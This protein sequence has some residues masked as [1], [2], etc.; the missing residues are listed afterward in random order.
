MRVGDVIAG[1]FVLTGRGASGGMGAVYQARDQQSGEGVA[2]KL[3]LSEDEQGVRRMLQEGAALAALSH[4][5]IVRY[6][7]HGTADNGLPYVAMEWVTGET[8]SHR[9]ARAPLSLAD[10]L[11]VVRQVAEALG[12][13]HGRGIVHRDVKPSNVMLS[14]GKTEGVKLLDFGVAR[15][16]RTASLTATHAV[17]GTPAYMAPEQARGSSELTPAADVFSLG[18]VLYRCLSGQPPFQGS[19]VIAILSKVLLEEPRDLGE[20]VPS[21]PLPVVALCRSLLSKPP[22]ERPPDG[23]AVARE[24]ERLEAAVA[25]EAA[26]ATA[27]IATLQESESGPSSRSIGHGELRLI[28]VLLASRPRSVAAD[29]D[30]VTRTVSVDLGKLTE[31]TRRHGGS[32]EQLLDGTLVISVSARGA[33]TDSAAS[34]ARLALALRSSLGGSKLVLATGRGAVRGAVPMGD[35]IDRAGAL[36]RRAGHSGIHIDAVTA[37]LL[38]ARFEVSGDDADLV[39]VRE[40]ETA[41]PA[42]TVL[43]KTTPFVG[44]ERESRLLFGLLEESAEE[45][46][47]AVALVTAPPG[48]GKS[49]LSHELIARARARDPN[50]VVLTAAADP[51]SDGAPLHVLA[52]LVRREAGL[53][54]GA[55]DAL[56]R[57]QLSARVARRVPAEDARRVAAFL[58]EV[59]RVPFP[60]A[61]DE[62]LAAA[63]RET[64]LMGDQILLAFVDFLSH[65]TRAAPVL[66]LLDDLHWADAPSVDILDAALRSLR[67]APLAI[68]GFARPEVEGR[69][70]RLFADRDLVKVPLGELAKKGAERLVRAVLGDDVDDEGVQRLVT[71]AAG[72]AFLLEELIRTRSEQRGSDVPESALAIV[73]ARLETLPEVSRRVLRA[74]SVFGNKFWSAG[75]SELLG[76]PESTQWSDST[77]DHLEHAE[78]IVRRPDSG[79][80]GH[81]EWTFRHALTRDAAYATLL[82]ADRVIGHRLAAEWLERIGVHDALMIAEHFERGGERLRAAA[83]LQR[84]A[85]QALSANDFPAV[86]ALAERALASGV[87]GATRASLQML[88]AD[89]HAWRGQNAAMAE[90]ALEARAGFVPGSSGWFRATGSAGFALGRSGELDRAE[91][92]GREALTEEPG[93]ELAEI[94]RGRALTRISLNLIL[95]HRDLAP[96]LLVAAD[97]V[98]KAHPNDGEVQARVHGAHALAASVRNDVGGYLEHTRLVLAARERF[99][100][101]RNALFQLSNLGDGLVRVGAHQ[102]A[103]ALLRRA[104]EQ[105]G[106]LGLAPNAA[107]AR[108]NLARAL[109]RQGRL[110]AALEVALEARQAFEKQGDPRLSALAN[111]GVADVCSGLGRHADALEAAERGIALAGD[112]PTAAASARAALVRALLDAQE[113]ARAD[114][115]AR[116]V[117][118]VLDELGELE[119]DDARA[120]LACAEAFRAAGALDLARG[121]LGEALRRLDTLAA[122]LTDPD[123]RERFSAMEENRRLRELE[124]ELSAAG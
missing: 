99:G 68:F 64:R 5:G 124:R 12:Y 20:L 115:Q 16:G 51:A 55:D 107:V 56:S 17:I 77:L 118:R 29:P 58:G 104:V 65:E 114:E 31:L 49:R 34:V 70:P 42:R 90:K 41:E 4:P 106:R 47:A 10:A 117:A 120:R 19:D 59:C 121:M 81:R 44:R 1:R 15:L 43:G 53:R 103:E 8:L 71:Q 108:H 26:R 85:E 84:A 13:A 11:R 54:L 91:Q 46:R 78:L 48:F 38:D 112:Y 37:G 25:P 33:A 24:L 101:V 36:L 18:C 109:A 96:E 23:L 7:A 119:E 61:D 100:D 75:V 14:V 60:D 63:R 22:E 21:L 105:A 97:E 28:S 27:N 88:Q 69:F 9:M 57:Q 93:D 80:S 39:L 35:V 72:N 113:I 67:D 102:E 123:L 87:A 40:K 92:L 94:E 95:A 110:E 66:V 98:G 62:Q 45:S 76:G 116:A 122:T 89:A 32:V 30:E 83:H 74:A 3:L 73:Q 2:L 86:I 50:T 52:D 82:D 79:L 111:A 6:V